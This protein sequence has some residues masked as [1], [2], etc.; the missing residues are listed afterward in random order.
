MKKIKIA[1]FILI[2]G[3]LLLL[4]QSLF[5]TPTYA[6]DDII[7]ESEES[8]IK[9]FINF[10]KAAEKSVKSVVH[11]KSKYLK[12]EIYRYYDP[13]YG[14]RYFNNPKEKVASGSDPSILALK[15][16]LS[17][18]TTSTSSAS[19]ITCILVI[20]Y[21]SLEI[22]TPDPLATFSFG[23]LKYLFP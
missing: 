10:E 21:P 2:G 1:F 3:F 14:N 12:D 20:M 6:N 18:K 19:L 9:S 22:I 8:E 16:L 5:L 4:I 7:F 11:I 17:F 15:V 13:F 23:L